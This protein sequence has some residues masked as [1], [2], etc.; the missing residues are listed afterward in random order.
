MFE[1]IKSLKKVNYQFHDLGK[2]V[3]IEEDDKIVYMDNIEEAKDKAYYHSLVNF[4]K[5]LN[6][7]CENDYLNLKFEETEFGLKCLFISDKGKTTE[8]LMSDEIIELHTKGN[9]DN[10]FEGYIIEFIKEQENK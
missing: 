6:E 10:D 5:R 8:L 2:E 4:V 9:D 7:K 3:W 1:K